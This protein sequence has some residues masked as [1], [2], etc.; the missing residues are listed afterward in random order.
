MSNRFFNNVINLISGTKARA[1]DV[2]AD[3][4]AVS[5]GFDVVQS[6]MDAKAPINNAALTGTPTAPTA[7]PGSSTTQLATTE[8]VSAAAFSAALPGQTGNSGKYLTTDGSSAS[9]QAL[10]TS[11]GS[12][13]GKP[14]TLTGYGIT[15]AAARTELGS[16]TVGD[17]VFIAASGSAARTALGFTSVGNALATATDAASARSSLGALAAGDNVGAADATTQAAKDSTTKVATTAFVDRL[18]GLLTSA[19]SGTLVLTDRG[20]R[21]PLS[22][23]VTVPS[24]VF[25]A[26]D[27][28]TLDN[29]TGASITITQGSGLTLRTA[30]GTTTGNFT[31][32]AHGLATMVFRSGTE[33]VISGNAG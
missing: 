22:A 10:I 27:V 28:V 7:A 15:M 3:L 32:A 12:I 30:G 26:N 5:A 11:W 4:T 6:E 8:F 25:A 29:T 24:A 13:T 14:T 9:W 17:A 19:T 2:E 23:G 18:R 21:V 31:L 1:G 20:C 16:T 33:A